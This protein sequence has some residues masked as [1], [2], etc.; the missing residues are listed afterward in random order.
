[1]GDLRSGV[2]G[3]YPFPPRLGKVSLPDPAAS[4]GAKLLKKRSAPE[5]PERF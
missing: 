5:V 2:R 3:D 4:Q 1:M